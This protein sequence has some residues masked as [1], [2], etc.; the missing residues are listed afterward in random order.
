M[1]ALRTLAAGVAAA[2]ALAV[3]Q[4]ARAD[5]PPTVGAATLNDPVFPN[6]GNGGYD[7]K[8][9]DLD[10]TWDP[11]ARRVR[12]VMTARAVASRALSGFSLDSAALDIATVQV[13]GVAARFTTSG[14]K[15]LITP[16]T[17]LRKG[18]SF[19]IVVV[20]QADPTRIPQPVGGFVPTVDGFATAGQPAAAHAV[21]PCNDHP[22][23]KAVFTFHITTPPGLIGVANGLQTASVSNPD[24]STTAT[25][26]Q[27]APM[28]TELAQIAVGQFTVLDHGDHKGVHLRDVAPTL[29]TPLLTPAFNLTPTQLDWITG[30][31]G[32]FP[33]QAYGLLPVNGATAEPFAFKGLETQTLTL[34]R[35]DY[36]LNPEDK[37]AG[38]MMHELT[39]SWFGDSVTPHTWADLWLNEGHAEY[40]GLNYRYFRGWTDTWGSNTFD[41]RMR[42]VYAKANQWRTDSGPVAQPT[43]TTLFDNERYTGGTLVLYALALRVGPRVFA[44]IEHTF[45]ARYRHATASTA[46]YIRTAVEVSHDPGVGPFLQAWLYGM[47]VPPM[48][49]RPQWTVDPVPPPPTTPMGLARL[50]TSLQTDSSE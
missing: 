42:Q 22:S 13:D 24:G 41:D 15:L 14:E 38:H 8:A 19:R 45:L 17:A 44:D 5:A 21:F 4:P 12:G 27:A 48:P 49:Q 26:S 40:Y 20:Y 16:A 39:H 31:L 3:A 46:D 47:T 9:Y 7:V 34:Y 25:F 6:L 2:S 11:I 10:V 37:I 50:R 23:D 35:A 36:L 30:Q 29:E 18:K 43:A 28:A 1:R 32:E 33:F